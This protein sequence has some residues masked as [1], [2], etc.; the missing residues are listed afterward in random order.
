MNV[1]YTLYTIFYA[2]YIHRTINCLRVV[3]YFTSKNPVNI[4]TVYIL[5]RR[6]I[7][8][9]P[10]IVFNI[11]IIYY[12]RYQN[13][14]GIKYMLKCCRCVIMM[15]HFRFLVNCQCYY[16]LTINTVRYNCIRGGRWI[17][18]SPTLDL[19]SG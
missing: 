3:R 5:F 2:C 18:C 19:L 8:L 14:F 10:T 1:E 17:D 16:L 6:V 12:S 9:Y 15:I 11:H 13:I 4:F 7:P